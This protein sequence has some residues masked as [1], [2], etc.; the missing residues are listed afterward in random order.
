MNAGSFRT[1]ID[2]TEHPAAAALDSY[3]PLLRR[4]TLHVLLLLM[5][6]ALATPLL[7][8]LAFWNRTWTGLG[9]GAWLFLQAFLAFNLVRLMAAVGAAL[10]RQRIVIASSALVTSLAMAIVL[11]GWLAAAASPDS[12]SLISLLADVESPMRSR[13][14]YVVLIGLLAWWRGISLAGRGHDVTGIG[15]R[16]RASILL[17][18]PFVILAGAMSGQSSTPSILLFF[19]ATLLAIALTRVEGLLDSSNR[20]ISSLGPTWLLSVAAIAAGLVL[21]AGAAAALVSSQAFEVLARWMTPVIDGIQL[22]FT[23]AFGVIALLSLPLIS[24]LSALLAAIFNRFGGGMEGIASQ[25]QQLADVATTEQL[26]DET[27][28]AAQ[29]IGFNIRPYLSYVGIAIVVLLV[30]LSL[31][32]V[33]RGLSGS[34]QTTALPASGT[35]RQRSVRDPLFKSLLDMLDFRRWRTASTI[36]RIYHD[37]CKLAAEAGSP[38]IE[39]ETP[40]EYLDTLVDLWPESASDAR[41]ITLAFIS[42]RYGQIPEE[43]L[44]LNLVR[45]AWKRIGS[46]K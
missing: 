24:L 42:V 16:F 26:G 11:S 27:I 20:H 30:G 39:T 33:F 1:E 28:E 46:R 14:I 18:I 4:E 44:G 31:N 37:M 17:V 13:L 35:D 10:R 36:R 32:R 21:A 43:E 3:W 40:L 8:A 5:E 38:R 2:A 41:T 25:L 9:L 7:L 34:G 29:M 23:F 45:S 22:T 12:P 6:V 15:L 19:A